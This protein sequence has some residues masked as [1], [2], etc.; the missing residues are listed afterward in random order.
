MTRVSLQ[1]VSQN[2]AAAW[3]GAL[4]LG[5]LPPNA[6]FFLLG[7]DSLIAVMIAAD[8]GERLGAEVGLADLLEAPTFD[9]FVDRVALLVAAGTG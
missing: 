7:G 8:L 4:N 6:N 2:V 3:C 1:E 9:E 5:S